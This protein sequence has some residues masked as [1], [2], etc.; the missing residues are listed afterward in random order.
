MF[1]FIIDFEIARTTF[2]VA[3]ADYF[4]VAKYYLRTDLTQ[5]HLYSILPRKKPFYF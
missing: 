3:K 5:F 2:Y 1:I 4:Y